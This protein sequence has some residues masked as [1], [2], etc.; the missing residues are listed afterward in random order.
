VTADALHCQRDHTTYLAQRGAHWILTV[1]G[2]QPSL[3]QQLA[4]LV[5][6]PGGISPPGSH[7]SVRE[8]LGSYGSCHLGRQ[9]KEAAVTHFQC[10]NIRGYLSAIPRMHARALR[11]LLSRSYLSRIQRTR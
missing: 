3:H 6:W 4:G 7:R 10:A 9:T 2:N 8:P 5:G 1:K 11:L